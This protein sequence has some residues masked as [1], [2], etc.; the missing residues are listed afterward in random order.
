MAT[1]AAKRIRGRER[2]ELAQ[3]LRRRVGGEVRYVS[4]ARNQGF[5]GVVLPRVAFLND[6]S[7]GFRRWFFKE[8]RPSRID[9]LLNN[10][11]WAF[12]MEQRYT[13]ALTTA[14]IGVPADGSLTITGPSRNER[15]FV[16]CIAGPGVR[17]DLRLLASWTP[18]PAVDANREPTWELP[19][20]PTQQHVEVLTKLRRS[21]RFERLQDP[22]NKKFQSGPPVQ[23]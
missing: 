23:D 5:M 16:D 8:C 12:D 3:E 15:E 9:A 17:V 13:I 10:A 20:L 1:A 14:Q 2:E 21:T 22:K 19:L 4:I 18:A 6:G 11:R 7:R